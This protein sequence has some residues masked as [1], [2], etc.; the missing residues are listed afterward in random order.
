MKNALSIII[1]FSSFFAFSQSQE[2]EIFKIAQLRD[3]LE[4]KI[5][6]YP[7]PSYGNFQVEVPEGGSVQIS[8]EN[9]VYVGTWVSSSEKVDFDGFPTGLYF[10]KI[11]I[12][13]RV[14]YKK[15][16]VLD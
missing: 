11:T 16:V 6:V 3:Q 1:V 13:E 5:V 15:L 10:L 9:G 2:N 14:F 4:Y 12:N 7:N 8:N